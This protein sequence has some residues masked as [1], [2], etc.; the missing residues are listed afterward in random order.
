[1]TIGLDD[2]V[3]AETALSHVDG[4]AGRLIIGGHDLEELAG[5]V[6]F[7]DVVAM[8]CS[9][10]APEVSADPRARLG[11]ARATAYGHLAP[12]AERLAGLTPVEGMRLLLWSLSDAQEDH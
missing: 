1:M 2:V 5:R 3:A 12:L 7:E 10:L 11:E 6:A 9:G 4:E 8:L